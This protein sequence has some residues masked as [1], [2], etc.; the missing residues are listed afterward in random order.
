MTCDVSSAVDAGQLAQASIGTQKPVRVGDQRITVAQSGFLCFKK[1]AWDESI[2]A[3]FVPF[4]LDHGTFS[5]FCRFITLMTFILFQLCAVGS[6]VGLAL[7]VRGSTG[8]VPAQDI[9]I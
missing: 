9:A 1:K 7:E 3:G 4:F 2:Y 8:H 5:E 6:K